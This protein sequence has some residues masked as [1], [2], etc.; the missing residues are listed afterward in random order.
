MPSGGVLSIKAR[1][2][3]AAD[4]PDKL[5]PGSYVRLSVTDTGVG[6]DSETLKRAAEPFFTTKPVG[7]GSGLGLS[8][9]HGLT[10]QSGGQMQIVSKQ[11]EGTTVSLWL[12]VAAEQTSAWPS[13]V[14]PP[15]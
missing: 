13:G 9:V 7:K 8:M 15:E 10:L 12:P 2:I 4:I 6:M 5:P 11:N 1:A 14:R 3:D